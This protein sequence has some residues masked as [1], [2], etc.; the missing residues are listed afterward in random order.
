MELHVGGSWEV[1]DRCGAI[2]FGQTIL[3]HFTWDIGDMGAV[4]VLAMTDCVSW[5][6][7]DRRRGKAG[8]WMDVGSEIMHSG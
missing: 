5:V 8:V 1:C 6:Y 2:L 7:W 4:V 3:F